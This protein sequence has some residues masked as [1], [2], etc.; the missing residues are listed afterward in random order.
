[1][2]EGGWSVS[3]EEVQDQGKGVLTGRK[4]QGRRVKYEQCVS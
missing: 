3:R 2:W 1:M 4:Y